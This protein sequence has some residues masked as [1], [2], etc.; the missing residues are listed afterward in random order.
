MKQTGKKKNYLTLLA[1]LLVCVLA[2]CGRQ[3]TGTDAPDEKKI[4]VGFSQVG[5]ESDWR[6]ANTVS[7]TTALSEEN[8]FRLI[9]DDAQNKQERQITAIR[10][11]IQM[12]VDYIVLAPTTETGWE[13][14]L[15]EAKAANIP[16]IIVDRM[17]N[18]EDSSLYSCWIGSDFLREGRSAT[19][20]LDTTFGNKPLRIVHL[21]GNLGCSAQLGRTNALAEALETHPSWEIVYQGPG[22]FL[23]AKG[24]EIL[25]D[26]LSR[27]VTFDVIYSENDNMAFGAIDALTGAGLVPGKDVTVVSFDGCHKALEMV[28]SGEINFVA[29]CNPLHGPRVANIINLLENGKAPDRFTFVDENTFDSGITQQM[30]D[31][32]QF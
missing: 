8:G 27:G 15:G 12:N 1:V 23:Q 22:D 24:Q 5:A 2:A 25:E 17:I 30:L 4:V 7:M 10:N 14:V 6:N 13:T 29:E 19:A 11:F 21:Q 32:R 26:L 20:W 16:V 28:F 18:V 31:K 3:N 9:I